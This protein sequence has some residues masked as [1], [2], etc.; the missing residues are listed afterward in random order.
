M[1]SRN[2]RSHPRSFRRTLLAVL[3]LIGFAMTTA[4][5]DDTVRFPPEPWGLDTPAGRCV[6]CHSLEQGGPFRV[7]PNLWDIVN[8]EK[9]RDRHWYAYSSALL[10][11]GGVWTEQDLDAFL[12]DADAYL[13]GT[14]K[15]ISVKDLEERRDIIEFLKTLQN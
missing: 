15:S 10:N 3:T 9:A 4:Q 11:K 1:P 8:A 14:T 5:A 6:V 13:P 2:D 12:A 7:A